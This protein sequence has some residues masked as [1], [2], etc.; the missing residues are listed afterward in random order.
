MGEAERA[1]RYAP[2]LWLLLGLFALRVLGQA[3]VA[4]AGVGWLPPMEQWMSG[5]LPYPWL[6]PAQLVILFVLGEV[7][8]DFTRGRGFSVTPR[9]LFAR[10]ALPFGR[11]Y[12]GSMVLRYLLSMAL[13]PERRW[14]GQTIP[15]VFHC[16]LASYV[17]LFGRYHRGIDRRGATRTFRPLGVTMRSSR[18]LALCPHRSKPS[19]GDPDRPPGSVPRDSLAAYPARSPG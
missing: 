15:I 17:I 16:V 12:L 18:F 2:W 19:P 6:L 10:W 14:I 3:L 7:A 4:F 8:A 9:R 1:R 13:H 11:V 5:L